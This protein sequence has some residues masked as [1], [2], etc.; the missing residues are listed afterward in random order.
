MPSLDGKH[1]GGKVT[2]VVGV[3]G[4]VVSVF[5]VWR[6]LGVDKKEFPDCA[7]WRMPAADAAGMSPGISIFEQFGA[8]SFALYWRLASAR[9]SVRTKL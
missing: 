7:G 8:L 1:E 9:S 5:F 2:Y 6:S 4:V 3:L